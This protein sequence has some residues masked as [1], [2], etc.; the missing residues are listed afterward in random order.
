MQ[1]PPDGVEGA[2]PTS[3]PGGELVPV[4]TPSQVLPGDTGPAP[5]SPSG[6]ASPAS[7]S[8][9][10]ARVDAILDRIMSV[11]R[12]AVLAHL[13][14]IR[15]KYPDASPQEVLR[16]LERRYLTTVTASGA[17]V[18]VAA[19][20]PA[21]GTGAALAISGAET[22]L[23]LESTALFAQSVAELHGIPVEDPDRGR[24]LVLAMVVGGP[25]QELITQFA[26]QATGSGQSKPQFW[27]ALIAKNL[28]RTAVTQFMDRVRK[29][30]LPRMM[31]SAG[32]GMV[33]RVLPFGVGAV[34]GGTA[35]QLLGR[36]VVGT[37]RTAFGP[38]PYVFPAST[39]PKVVA[40][41]PRPSRRAERAVAAGERRAIRA[42][43]KRQ[44]PP[45]PSVE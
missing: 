9:T 35:N 12:P 24:A 31:A 29:V 19:A 43:R 18:G 36:R 40:P 6:E 1:A 33:A 45:P 26:G 7:G 42:A 20:V 27:G 39:A 13:R 3:A 11:H 17:G 22:V 25:A 16:I 37:A 10:G 23:F 30:Y 14:G 4:V 32:G 15:S 8:V 34:V 5:G 41:G 21:V 2:A 38:P 44:P 28:P